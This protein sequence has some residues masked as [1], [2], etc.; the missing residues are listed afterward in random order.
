MEPDISFVA[1]LIGDTA[2]AKMLT[3]LMGGKAL[4]AT[5]LAIEADITAQTASSHLAK[6][7]NGELVVVRKQGRHKYFQL[8]DAEVAGLIEKLLNISSITT[9]QKVVTGPSDPALRKARV[10]YDHL[11]G[12]LGVVLY[13]TLISQGHIVDNSTELVVSTQGKVFFKGLGID[14]NKLNKTKRPIC[15]ACLDWSERRSHL[16]GSLGQWILTD[17]F[18]KGWATKQLDS[19]AIRFTRNG[20]NSF[21]KQYNLPSTLII[22]CHI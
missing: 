19:R 10:C 1:S 15:K 7:V 3:A 11:A 18:S 17:I 6:L 5:E 4:T 14:F 12:E 20:S 13:D 21:V 22:S 9:H 16:S 8:K 2:R